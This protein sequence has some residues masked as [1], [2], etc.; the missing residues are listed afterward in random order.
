MNST[1]N[2]I[3]AKPKREDF[4]NQILFELAL[5]DYWYCSHEKN[6]PMRRT[7]ESIEASLRCKLGMVI[8][9]SN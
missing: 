7:I 9:E 8:S 1:L 5:V 2:H 4:N 6:H 3:T